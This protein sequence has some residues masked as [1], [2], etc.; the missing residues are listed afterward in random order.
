MSQQTLEKTPHPSRVNS[1]TRFGG[2]RGNI[3]GMTRETARLAVE[4]KLRAAQ[5]ISNALGAVEVI[6]EDAQIAHVTDE[7]EKPI[8]PEEKRQRRVASA[9]MILTKLDTALVRTLIDAKQMG[10]QAHVPGEDGARLSDMDLALRMLHTIARAMEEAKR[11]GD[12]T[13]DGTAQEVTS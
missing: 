5:I 10:D 6:I 8:T 11:N 7:L 4:N 13:I 12:L 1:P 9:E 2:P 3:P